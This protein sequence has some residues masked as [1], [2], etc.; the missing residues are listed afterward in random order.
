LIRPLVLLPL[1]LA[2]LFLGKLFNVHGIENGPAYLYTTSLMLALGLYGST[3]GIDVSGAR[4]DSRLIIVAVSVGV[5]LKSL[6]I[7]GAV[8]VILRNPLDL[9]LGVVVAQIDPLSVASMVTNRRLSKRAYSILAAWSAFDDAA[10]AVLAVY[11]ALLLTKVTG[12]GSSAVQGIHPATGLAGWTIDVALNFAVAGIALLLWRSMRNHRRRELLGL[13]LLVGVF[14]LAVLQ[15]LMLTAALVGLF[16]R[17]R[18]LARALPPMVGSALLVATVMLG[19]LL[20]AGVDLKTGVAL[21]VATF[22]AQIV[23]GYGLTAGLPGRDRTH[24]ALAQQ[25]GLT[26]I[27]LALR[28]QEQFG[29]VV[30]A[31]APAIVVINLIYVVANWTLDAGMKTNV[32]A[33]PSSTESTASDPKQGPDGGDHPCHASPRG[34]QVGAGIR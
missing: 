9:L 34:Y 27:I 18:L 4:R 15:F 10:T 6:L 32:A 13:L 29:G 23:V 17:P 22:A 12:V 8:Y 33:D 2:G 21:G 25:N 24:L 16:L 31:V 19:T 11:A 30:A 28:L 7:G 14:A 3:Y 5:V 26:A 20:T 1:L